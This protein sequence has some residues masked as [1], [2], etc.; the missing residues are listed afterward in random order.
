MLA[1]RSFGEGN[2]GN[3]N[4]TGGSVSVTNGGQLLAETFNQGNAGNITI[5]A[6][7]GTVSFNGIDNEGFS[8]G[9]RSDVRSEATGNAGNIEINT[10]SLFV[11]AGNQIS[12]STFG[13]GN[14]GNIIINA[15]TGTVSFDGADN[16]GFPSGLFTT[17]EAG[18]EGKGGDINITAR[19]LSLTNGGQ[20]NTFVR[21]NS[22]TEPG[23]IG[24]AGNVKLN[25]SDAINI[26][27]ASD[28][29]DSSGNF[30]RSAIFSDVENGAIG[31]AGNIEIAT[32]HCL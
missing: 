26:A 3:I 11:G 24:D 8:S 22:D 9:I 31:N 29:P 12:S 27:G 16:Q 17:V 30:S 4:I 20:L 1:S 23:G 18:G 15:P 32:A 14:A 13:K 7:T 19:S 25:V 5:N 21:E 28:T 6:P 10:G 2:A